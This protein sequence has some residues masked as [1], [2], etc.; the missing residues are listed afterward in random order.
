MIRNALIKIISEYPDAIKEPIKNHNLVKFI[1]KTA[2]ESIKSNLPEKLY[3]DFI[4]LCFSKDKKIREFIFTNM[5]E[6]WLLSNHHKT[7]Y[8]STYIHLKGESEPAVNVIID[9]IEN[10]E[11]KNKLIELTFDLDKIEP[12]HLMA[13]DCIIRLEQHIL[14]N[15]LTEL[16]DK[17]KSSDDDFDDN[18]LEQLNSLEKQISQLKNKYNEQ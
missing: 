6:N 3:D 14:K 9:Q 4:R 17:L 15:S 1:E 16:R 5:N 12:N 8:E 13:V 7:I 10:K 18:V 2:V 11:T